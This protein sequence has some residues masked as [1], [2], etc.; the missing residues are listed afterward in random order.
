[1]FFGGGGMPTVGWITEG[2]FDRWSAEMLKVPD[3]VPGFVAPAFPCPFCN[4]VCH[5][6]KQLG[7][8]IGLMHVGLRPFLSI[9]GHEPA[10]DVTYTQQ[11]RRD[12]I[13]L[14]NVTSAEM[15]FNGASWV[16]VPVDAVGRS[17][18]AQTE[19]RVQV[20]LQNWFDR[21]ALPSNTEYDFR[22]QV[23][24]T[25]ELTRADRIFIQYFGTPEASIG[26]VDS[27]LLNFQEGPVRRYAGALADYVVAVL[28]KD[29]A[30]G[31]I[32][33]N[34]P[35][36]YRSIFNGSLRV[37]ADFDRPL[38]KL[39]C[40]IMR[41]GANDFSSEGA[42]DGFP[43]L[44]RASQ[45]FRSLATGDTL[46]ELGPQPGEGANRV[47]V[48]PVDAGTDIILAL[49]DQLSSLSR[50]SRTIEDN[51]RAK[52]DVPSLDPLDRIKLLAIWAFT[53]L[54]L[55][56]LDGAS[57]PLRRLDG[58]DRFGDWAAKHL[59]EHNL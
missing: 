39:L 28:K 13:I 25:D 29:V 10:S 8:H 48:C 27:Y 33:S 16:G 46:P 18:S 54:R 59:K 30:P 2:D 50:W 57:E 55:K 11:L 12:S 43:P 3:P 40:S 51:L 20:R 9:A 1:M 37:L 15:R 44:R 45:L 21:N 14:A 42:S 17:L 23:I 7:E 32:T 47:E 34:A 53:A 5:T 58:N 24:Q 35:E 22:F 52:S 26:A 19:G 41:F 56:S 49:C 36:S 31:R 4:M 38:P 6:A